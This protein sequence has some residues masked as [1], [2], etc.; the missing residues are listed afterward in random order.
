MSEKKFEIALERQLELFRTATDWSDLVAYL[1]G[2]EG[3]LR[4]NKYT[5]IPKPHMLYRR[6]NQ[7]LNPALPAGVHM[8]AL[9][10][11][12]IV[13]SKVSKEHLLKEI[14]ILT[15]GLFSF[16][17]HASLTSISSYLDVIKQIIEVLED[18]TIRIC[19]NLILGVI[20]GL[21]EDNSE[22]YGMTLRVLTV[23]EEKVGAATVLEKTW[24]VMGQ[25]TELVPGCLMYILKMDGGL[26]IMKNK[27]DLLSKGF[28]SALQSKEIITLRKGFD[29]LLSYKNDGLNI[30]L[31]S[32]M[33]SVG[34]LKLLLL[35][36]ISL[37]KRVQI[38]ITHLINHPSGTNQLFISL[39]QIFDES[40]AAY[41][42]ILMAI[43]QNIEEAPKIFERSIVWILSTVDAKTKM[44]AQSFLKILDR[45]IVWRIIL[46]RPLSTD[47]VNKAIN[48]ELIDEQTQSYELPILISKY[49]Q[50]DVYPYEWISIIRPTPA[51]YKEIWRD[52]QKHLESSKNPLQIIIFFLSIPVTTDLLS[53]YTEVVGTVS[54]IF[55]KYWRQQNLGKNIHAEITT[56]LTKIV[57]HYELS[58]SDSILLYDT[59]IKYPDIFWQYDEL[60]SGKLQDILIQ[61]VIYQKDKVRQ[62]LDGS[63][64]LNL[65]FDLVSHCN[66][67]K[68]NIN[69]IIFLV[70]FCNSPNY[71]TR[72]CAKTFC[73]KVGQHADIF[74]KII[75][76]LNY[77]PER[78]LHEKVC[79]VDCDYNRVLF[80]LHTL[81]NMLGC[82][83]S[84]HIF[85]QENQ[86]ILPEASGV[87]GLIEVY[88]EEGEKSGLA[89]LV[90]LLFMYCTAEYQS[91]EFM[92]AIYSANK[93]TNEFI[94]CYIR[95]IRETSVKIL[96][97]I[98]CSETIEF[99][100]VI[101]Q[102][103][104]TSLLHSAVTE[105]SISYALDVFLRLSKSEYIDSVVNMFLTAKSIRMALITY[106]VKEKRADILLSLLKTSTDLIEEIVN[107]ES[108]GRTECNMRHVEYILQHCVYMDSA[109]VK[110]TCS[111]T[112]IIPMISEGRRKVCFCGIVYSEIF[113]DQDIGVVAAIL[114]KLY[115]IFS[116]RLGSLRVQEKEINSALE[117]EYENNLEVISRYVFA[118]HTKYKS[119]LVEAVLEEYI[120]TKRI[121]FISAI[122][123]TIE[124]DVF[125]GLLGSDLRG[126]Y[127]LLQKWTLYT[128]NRLIFISTQVHTHISTILSQIKM[129]PKVSDLLWFCMDYLKLVGASAGT[130]LGNKI[131]DGCVVFSGKLGLKKTIIDR[132]DHSSDL[133]E[134][135]NIIGSVIMTAV[136]KEYSL[137][138]IS[139]WNALIVP[140]FKFNSVNSLYTKALEITKYLVKL[141]E[142]K[143]CKKEFFEY[144]QGE[145][146]FKDTLENIRIKV[147]IGAQLVDCEKV[148]DLVIRANTTSFF[149]RE[150]DILFRASLI[151]RVRYMI[152]CAPS[153]EYVENLPGIFSLISEI[154]AVSSGCKALLVEIF[155]LCRVLCIKM[156]VDTLI[157]MWPISVSEA[158]DTLSLNALSNG[159]RSIA[160]SAL[161]FLDL[162]AS[163]NYPELIEFRWLVENLPSTLGM[164]YE[165]EEGQSETISKFTI[166]HRIPYISTLSEKN[167][168]PL[169]EM[170]IQVALHHIKQRNCVNMDSTAIMDSVVNGLP[171]L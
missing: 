163:L 152:L 106:C 161:Q 42:K 70:S 168:M 78:S 68:I 102:S 93:T 90:C 60:F 166:T 40:P 23:L 117:Y 12:K 103:V 83:S 104:L 116:D 38:W 135:L 19:K 120:T 22:Q 73:R 129:Y 69:L 126:K 14:N 39:C 58:G 4:V 8:K 100:P 80:G 154:F 115:A 25:C 71:L 149:I 89:D 11:Y 47:L 2:L 48:Y 67:K 170:I 167:N 138:V 9:G 112:D 50:N 143:I 96:R 52:I 125:L 157:N 110:S 119:I 148:F 155:S 156:P 53:T 124:L 127:Q 59:A 27:T 54:K 3:I 1:T 153:G 131:L 81:N 121:D 84:F 159:N 171:E 72:E 41:F 30:H 91:S 128:E 32:G 49:L 15:L 146:F 169:D 150:S 45:R 29:L 130:I 26:E 99:W 123:K 107:A 158:I 20:M 122:H 51:A 140:C 111:L 16:Y 18:K 98:L 62:S 77:P 147:D 87:S 109:G 21:E 65:V 79:I 94:L 139:V 82:S 162:V 61:R 142:C 95:E 160:Y 63:K 132:I 44:H 56:A 164:D 57:V 101:H 75:E 43:R 134:L 114:L 88:I 141:P 92:G 108:A 74:K 6:L 137:D 105:Q 64:E 37:L 33:V 46:E 31:N 10:V 34:V 85:L 17:S 7:C 136:E 97:S 165:P 118:I 13:M 24:E 145:R 144:I 86:N 76:G 133:L 35:K 66:Y 28:V 5:R 55:V 36:E 113:T 151:K